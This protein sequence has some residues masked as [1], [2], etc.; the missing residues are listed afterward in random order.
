MSR[1][2]LTTVVAQ[3]MMAVSE[4]S[5]SLGEMLDVVAGFHE[6]ELTRWVDWFTRLFE[7]ILMAVIGIVIG[8]V[9]VF[10]YMPVFEL[11]ETIQ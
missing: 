8:F 4:R 11:A 5:G 9:V 6:E 10:M 7:P 3:S 2:G 1:H